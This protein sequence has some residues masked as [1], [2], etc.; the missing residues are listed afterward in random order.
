MNNNNQLKNENDTAALYLLEQ[1]MALLFKPH[2]VL[3]LF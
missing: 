3:Q 1:A 2:C